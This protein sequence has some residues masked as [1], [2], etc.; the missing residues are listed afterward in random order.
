LRAA[1]LLTEGD[2]RVWK[3]KSRQKSSRF[4]FIPAID[5]RAPIPRFPVWRAGAAARCS[6][7]FFIPRYLP[8]DFHLPSELP[9]Q[10]LNYDHHSITT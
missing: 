10:A 6:H 9:T 7:M 3:P 8:K 2:D 5:I 1:G 4:D